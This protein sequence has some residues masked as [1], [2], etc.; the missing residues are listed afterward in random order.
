MAALLPFIHREVRAYFF[1]RSEVKIPSN[2]VGNDTVRLVFRNDSK[3]GA[4]W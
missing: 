3:P 1:T 4:D 2:P